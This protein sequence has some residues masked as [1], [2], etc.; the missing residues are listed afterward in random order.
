MARAKATPAAG[1]A[2]HDD[3]AAWLGRQ[4]WFHGRPGTSTVTAVERTTVPGPTVGGQPVDD[5]AGHLVLSLVTVDD[6]AGPS[7]YQLVGDGTQDDGLDQPQA[8]AALA[9][10]IGSD[11]TVT[12][13]SGRISF[14]WIDEQPPPTGLARPLGAEQ[15]NTSLVLADRAV[16]KVFRRLR[17]G[18]NPELEML[19]FLTERRFEHIAPLLGWYEVDGPLSTTLGV[20]QELVVDGRDGWELALE[21]LRWDA[22]GLLAH[23]HRLG[24]VVASL[25]EVLASDTDDPDFGRV[26][27]GVDASAALAE[28]IGDAAAVILPELAD[29]PGCEDL[30]DRGPEVA[31]LASWL[32]ADLDAGPL[33]RHHGDLHLGQTLW[34]PDRWVLL[35]FEGEPIRPVDERRERRPALRDVAGLLRS[36]AYAVATIERTGAPVAPGWEPAA[37]AAVLDGYLASA[38]P[39]TIP[40]AAPD[41]RRLLALHELEK[42]VYEIG[43]EV[44]HRPTWVA[45]PA[46]ALRRTIDHGEGAAA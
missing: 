22:G 4:R 34:T 25:H 2:T 17:D 8:A 41:V 6:G 1:A 30:A 32:A 23:L 28:G 44:A 21:M 20:A 35:D 10:A 26:E 29:V 19:R 42:V 37:R 13:P 9:R 36:L 18:R 38:D 16:L 24:A 33:I 40:A 43:Y 11:V 27:G 15:S 45:I 39:A 12:G 3:L 14:R 7:V 31:A 5:V 46:G